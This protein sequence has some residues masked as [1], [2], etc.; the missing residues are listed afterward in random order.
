VHD[1]A[2][3]VFDRVRARQYAELYGEAS[4]AF[5]KTY[6]RAEFV[7]RL[8]ALE[9][10][11]QLVEIEPAGEP[12]IVDRDAGRV[13]TASYVVRFAFAEGP[14]VVKL[15]ANEM[16]GTWELE[17]YDYDVAVTTADPPYAPDDTGADQLARRFFYLW[18]SRRYGDLRR[19]MRLSDD[20]QKVRGFLEKLENAGKLLTLNRRSYETSTVK[21]RRTAQARYDLAG[22][23]GTGNVAFRLV[24][25]DREWRIESVDYEIEYNKTR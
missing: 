4:V 3:A 19:A 7:R 17:G 23:N 1:A 24:E 8:E 25:V 12:S 10:F 14:F 22:D 18:Q 9:A 5:R 21:G 20:P 13:A 2:Q 16:L 6:P 11:G 15:R